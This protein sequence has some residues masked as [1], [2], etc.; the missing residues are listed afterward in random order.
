MENIIIYF[1][2][3]GTATAGEDMDGEEVTGK[4]RENSRETFK[5]D[6][7]RSKGNVTLDMNEV[8]D[9][10][11]INASYIGQFNLMLITPPFVILTVRAISLSHLHPTHRV[12]DDLAA[13][14]VE[15]SK[16]CLPLLDDLL[17]R[18]QRGLLVDRQPIAPRLRPRRHVPT[19]HCGAMLFR[20]SQ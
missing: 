18:R 19:V 17:H 12:I 15:R 3:N 2:Q 9:M 11:M 7:G 20:I 16:D 13:L 8:I 10:L 5:A 1:Q 14:A 6:G 4:D